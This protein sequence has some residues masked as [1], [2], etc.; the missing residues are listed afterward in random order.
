MSE[1]LIQQILDNF[2]PEYQQVP[3]KNDL[4]DWLENFLTFL[5]PLQEKT[6]DELQ[7]Q[8]KSN[9]LEFTKMLSDM[10]LELNQAQ[11][12]TDEF[13][14]LTPQLLKNLQQDAHEFLSKDPAASCLGEILH[15]Y[16]GFY[17][18]AIYR[19][20]H[21]MAKDLSLEY[22]PRMLTEHAHSRTGIDIHPSAQIDSPFF[23][24]HGTGVVIGETCKIGKFVNIYQGVTLGALQ[25]SKELEGIKRHPTVEDHVVI[26]ANAT[27]LG[28]NT[29]VGNNSVIGG[30]VF[31]TKSVAPY[32]M[33]FTKSETQIKAITS[34]N[35]PINF[36][37]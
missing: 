26:Y 31:L 17:A 30:N 15:T 4:F 14:Q 24:D 33:V 2:K 21:I 34:E 32:S 36:S 19:I 28:G 10:Q 3:N 22:V 12:K 8:L 25:V 7:I 13:Y 27:I 16:P 37:I 5:F 29:I 6:Y 1:I 20:A 18:I 11:Q 35:E 23:I 9:Q